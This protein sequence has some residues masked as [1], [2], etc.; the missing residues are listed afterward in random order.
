MCVCVCVCV[1]VC[2]RAHARVRGVS[3]NEYV[4]DVQR[5]FALM[6][7]LIVYQ[8]IACLGRPFYLAYLD[9]VSGLAG[10]AFAST[11]LLLYKSQD[12]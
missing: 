3:D 9:P 4:C 2:A 7:I 8:C 11:S 6:G 1:C 5:D 10:L 12:W